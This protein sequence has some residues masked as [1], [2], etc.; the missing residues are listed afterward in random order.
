MPTTLSALKKAALVGAALAVLSAPAFAQAASDAPPAP[1]EVAAAPAPDDS[2]PPRPGPRGPN[3]DGPGPRGAGPG[4]AGPHG[5]GPGGFGPGGFGPGGI[6]LPPT[7][8]AVLVFDRGGPGGRIVIKCAD[9]DS[10]EACVKAIAPL[11]DKGLAA[12]PQRGPK[13]PAPAQ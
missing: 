3:G 13:G 5:M 8:G 1:D 6:G 12:L 4:M 2:A 9:S 11:F 7:K 10:T